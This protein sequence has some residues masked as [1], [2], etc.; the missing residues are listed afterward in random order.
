MKLSAPI[1][2][3]KQQAR[4]LSRREAIPLH[5]ALDRI[6]N[7]EGFTAW[8]LLSAKATPTRKRPVSTLLAQLRSGDLVLLGSRRGQGKTLL[9]IELAIRM[10]QQGSQAAFFTLDFTATEVANCFKAL[11]VDLGEFQD[12][13]LVDTSDQICAEYILSKLASAPANMLVVIDY[14]Q[15]LDQKRENP[16]LTSQVQQLR[17]FARERQL[18]ILCLSQIDR[19]YDSTNRPC[20][21]ISD[22]RLPNPLDL[23]LF[24]KT[25]FLH[26]DTMQIASSA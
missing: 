20:P 24:D 11:D 7:Q 25:C 5:Q 21:E 19:R 14:L 18:I 10:M 9:S 3:L 4:V 1:Y 22:V 8:S 15:L 2:V 16:D 23:S 12:R 6:A 13:F 26:Q 17:S